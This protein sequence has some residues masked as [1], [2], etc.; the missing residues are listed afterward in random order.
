MQ[1]QRLNFG[2][3][4]S[5]VLHQ[6]FLDIST[7]LDTSTKRSNRMS[8]FLSMDCQGHYYCVLDN[9]AQ[10]FIISTNLKSAGTDCLLLLLCSINR[11]CSIHCTNQWVHF[12]HVSAFLDDGS[13]CDCLQQINHILG[14]T[15]RFKTNILVYFWFWVV[16]LPVTYI[17]SASKFDECSHNIDYCIYKECFCVSLVL[18]VSFRKYNKERMDRQLLDI[19]FQVKTSHHVAVRSWGISMWLWLR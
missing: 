4:V 14:E 2:R 8:L 3:L 9:D 7:Y 17:S 16:P 13:F 6:Q 12:Y 10:T 11:E 19:L 5:L 15:W 1:T 18:D